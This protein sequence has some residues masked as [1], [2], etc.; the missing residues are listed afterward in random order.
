MSTYRFRSALPAIALV[1]LLGVSAGLAGA[2]LPASTHPAIVSFGVVTIGT[3][4]AISNPSAPISQSGSS[5]LLTGNLDGS[6]VVLA[7]N[8]TIDGQG[9]QV[10]YTRGES[11][12]DN[13]AVTV[14]GAYGDLVENFLVANATTGIEVNA[15]TDVT[16]SGNDLTNI[17][18][19]IEHV[20]VYVEDSTNTIVRSN[21]IDNASSDGIDLYQ[22]RGV[23]VSGNV[24]DNSSAA[25]FHSHALYGYYLSDVVVTNNVGEG[26][27]Y[28]FELDD[29]INAEMDGNNASYSPNGGFGVDGVTNVLIDHNNAFDTAY[30]LW[31]DYSA[32]VTIANNSAAHSYIPI[33]DYEDTDFS[34]IDNYA[35][36]SGATPLYP[37]AA[38]AI[39]SYFS[40]HS[41]FLGNDIADAGNFGALL[42]YPGSI[43]L[44]NNDI[45]NPSNA[46][47]YV[48]DPYG[49]VNITGN[50][51]ANGTAI[52]SYGVDALDVYADLSVWG[53]NFANQSQGVYVDYASVPISIGDNTFYGS[54]FGVDLAYLS[55]TASVEG[56]RFTAVQIGVEDSYQYS[57]MLDLVNNRMSGFITAGV[58]DLGYDSGGAGVTVAHNVIDNSSGEAVDL[59]ETEG[60]TTIVNNDLWNTSTGVYTDYLYGGPLSISGNNITHSGTAIDLYY[61]GT[62]GGSAPVADTPTIVSGNDLARS[63]FG[64][65]EYS[66]TG[67]LTVTGNDLA[68]CTFGVYTEYNTGTINIT[69]NVVTGNFIGVEVYEAYDGNSVTVSGNNIDHSRDYGIYLIYD[70][71]PDLVTGNSVR[72][73]QHWA[74]Y[75]YSNDLGGATISNNND[76]G[77]FDALNVTFFSTFP[78]TINGNDLSRSVVVNV[79]DSLVESFA[80]N[81]LLG[82]GYA[83]FTYDTIGGFYHNDLPSGAFRDAGDL[84]A[85]GT[86]NAAYPIGG[87]YWTGYA[88]TDTH[89]G[90]EQNLAGADGIGDTAYT[91]DGATDAYPLMGPWVSAA[92]TFTETGL[93]SGAT[94]SVTFNGLTEAGV[95]GGSISF[96]QV[97]GASTAFSY[98]AT[99]P[100]SSYR[101]TSGTGTMTGANQHITVAFAAVTY[102][103]TFNWTEPAHLV[104]WS[105]TFNGVTESTET[106]S[107]VF[108]ATNGSYGYTVT[109]PA[110][111]TASPPSGTVSVAGAD[112]TVGLTLTPPMV[113]ITFVLDAAVGGGSWSVALNGAA[114]MQSTAL[115]F[116]VSVPAGYYTYTITLPSGYT[117]TPSMATINATHGATVY[118]AVAGQGTSTSG[119][120]GGVAGLSG[121][122][123]GLLAGLVVVALIAALGWIFYMRKPR[124]GTPGPIAPY[125]AGAPSAGPPPGA[126]NGA[127]SEP[128][129]GGPGHP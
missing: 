46:G 79:S 98:T 112:R 120:S 118:L 21:T 29:T 59:Y 82:D 53:N 5:Y 110:G 22:D 19:G 42:Y 106:D 43:T 104:N 127:P 121:L 93:P 7:S 111:F 95:S 122:D 119:G 70:Y 31:S 8:V 15:S 94:W 16:V 27:Y 72:F 30:S 90:P 105:V 71:A 51:I 116:S 60:A 103:V 6:L 55:A 12:G 10:N 32:N 68:N 88:G 67:A 54:V 1:V 81:N 41:L 44:A 13:A 20:G 76:T 84:V 75:D 2:A 73:A 40:S 17:T 50:N 33:Y 86:W 78:V 108:T 9:F 69:A 38:E 96:A 48:Y 58:E 101:G 126:A 89:S 107:L 47:V 14:Q 56:N 102:S 23:T 61:S 115:S 77:S 66:G 25:R 129:S 49:P 91:L 64:V 113:T 36:H 24:L 65:Y 128:S 97:N 52:G 39:Y 57:G 83:N 114:P 109:P 34:A 37:I 63:T 80:A 26:T 11:G 85:T 62:S 87:N 100:S 117:A 4:G 45:Y 123:L 28:G 92:V 35:P 124:Q 99:P 3:N 125:A 74:I 18:G